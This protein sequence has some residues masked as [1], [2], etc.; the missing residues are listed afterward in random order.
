MNQNNNDIYFARIKANA[1][2]LRICCKVIMIIMIVATSVSA[3]TSVAMLAVPDDL[4]VY[5]Y[6]S[7]FT[8]KINTV[9]YV[10]TE[11][12]FGK[13]LIESIV[14]SFESRG[15]TVTET[16]EGFIVDSGKT[17]EKLT[18]RSM[19]T[20]LIPGI[21]EMVV[22]TIIFF[23]LSSFFEKIVNGDR[24]FNM[25]A[26]SVLRIVSFILWGYVVLK[27]IMSLFVSES[28]TYVEI[29]FAALVMFFVQIYTYEARK[30]G[31]HGFSDGSDDHKDGSDP[32]GK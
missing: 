5:D 9:D 23:F 1:R 28:V 32:F 27:M 12:A 10:N 21:I 25:E 14:S 30:T 6:E 13:S 11:S 16:D 24:L 22:I 7:G 15:Y 18:F 4:M 19:A 26:A 17:T 20:S 29:I 2:F 31:S 3:L 8:I